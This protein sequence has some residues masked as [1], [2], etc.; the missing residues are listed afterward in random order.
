MG[1]PC[2]YQ[3]ERHCS[4]THVI[5]IALFAGVITSQNDTAPKPVRCPWHNDSGVITSQNDTAPKLV[6]LQE[7][8]DAV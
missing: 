7:L 5:D 4:K 6:M 8:H 1:T 3:S 2:D